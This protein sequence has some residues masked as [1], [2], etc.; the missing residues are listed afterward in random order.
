MPKNKFI[1]AI[2]LAERMMEE[3]VDGYS[4][5]WGGVGWGGVGRGGVGWGEVGW[6]CL[7]CWCARLGFLSVGALCRV[8]MHS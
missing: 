3:N 1:F 8:V 5:V 6:N 2:L 4:T 7:P